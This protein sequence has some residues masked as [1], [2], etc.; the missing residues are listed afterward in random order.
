M[1][2]VWHCE[3]CNRKPGRGFGAF[4][5]MFSSILFL[6]LGISAVTC[7]LS[8]VVFAFLFPQRDLQLFSGPSLVTIFKYLL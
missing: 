4:P 2:D 7:L 3:I 6:L 8:S 5:S 1:Q